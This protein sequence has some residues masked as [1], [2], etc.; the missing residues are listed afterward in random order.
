MASVTFKK[1]YRKIKKE[2]IIKSLFCGL[3]IGFSLAFVCILASWLAGAK[4]GLYAGIALFVVAAAVAS[5]LFYR[6]RFRPTAKAIAKR[7]DALGL[8]ERVLTMT[9]LEHDDSFIAMKQ[10]EDALRAVSEVNS[11]LLKL[12]ISVP[13][14]VAV[15]LSATL[16]TGMTVVSALS[17]EGGKQLIESFKEKQTFEVTYA[18]QGKGWVVDFS[19][20]ENAAL[21]ESV[22]Q[23]EAKRDELFG[24]A[25]ELSVDVPFPAEY[26]SK[27]SAAVSLEGENA[28]TAQAT[29]VLDGVNDVEIKYSFTV[30][31]GEEKSVTLLAL[32]Q[33]GWVFV[34]W[35]D[36]VTSPYRH[37]VSVTGNITA[38]AIFDEILSDAEEENGQTS[39]SGGE[40]ESTDSDAEA[41]TTPEEGKQNNPNSGGNGDKSGAKESLANQIIDGG[42]YYGDVFDNYFEE[43][44]ERLKNN[45]NLTEAQKKAITDYL[46]SI[47]K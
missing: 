5:P 23:R 32:P 15:A 27:L 21:I 41:E 28:G 43:N 16:G 4:A 38:T 14:I 18:V 34:G 19:K 22:K 7:I 42:T 35:S 29:I 17:P 10:R 24:D 6:F 13:M 3:I 31:E 39:T 33:N 44:I 46:E 20:N 30:T 9:E 8:E 40:G 1:Y 45:E 2:S 11:D 12:A 25:P 37:E 26:S 36:G 47:R